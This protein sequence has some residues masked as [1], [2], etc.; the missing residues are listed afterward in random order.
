MLEAAGGEVT[1][2]KEI[3]GT[4][5]MPILRQ[6]GEF[7]DRVLCWHFP[8]Y[9]QNYGKEDGGRDPL[10]RTRPGSTMRMGKWK[11][12]EYFEDGGIELYNLENDLGETKNLAAKMP[13][14]VSELMKLLRA[15]RDE[16]NAP[17]PT[18]LNP[19]YDPNLKKHR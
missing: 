12:H 9:L 15:W 7:P 11:L 14:K 2:G 18:K 17:V 4:S 10:F 13:E 19:H 16:M 6:K 5:L 8:I 1:K 3:D